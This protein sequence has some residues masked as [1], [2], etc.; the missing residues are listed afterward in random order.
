MGL[1]GFGGGNLKEFTHKHIVLS[2]RDYGQVEDVH[3]VLDHVISYMVKD[4][5][6]ND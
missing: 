5:I 4:R 1:I 3:L 2:S 6:A